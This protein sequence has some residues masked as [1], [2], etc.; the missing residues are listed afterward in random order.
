M[1]HL[2][3][4]DQTNF[5]PAV[6]SLERIAGSV[7]SVEQFMIQVEVHWILAIVGVTFDSTRTAQLNILLDV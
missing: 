3:S 7:D 2:P 4:W 6:P 5:F 1:S